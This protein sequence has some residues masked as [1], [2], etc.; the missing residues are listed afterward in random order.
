MDKNYKGPWAVYEGE[1]KFDKID[2][3]NIFQLDLPTQN[4]NIKNKD[5]YL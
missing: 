4:F 5:K 1:E 2:N 3:N